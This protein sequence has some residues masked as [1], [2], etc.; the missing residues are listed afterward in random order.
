MRPAMQLV[1]RA[2]QFAA[3]IRLYKDNQCIDGKS[4]MQV[5]MLAATQGTELRI[6]AQ[7]PDAPQAVQALAEMI[8]NENPAENNK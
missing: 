3:R 2:N 4:I 8:E 5:T 1:E 6:T 7:G